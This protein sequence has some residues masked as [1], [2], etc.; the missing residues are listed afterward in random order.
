MVWYESCWTG[1]WDRRIGQYCD[2]YGDFTMHF[3]I[4]RFEKCVAYF[5]Q[6]YFGCWTKTKTAKS[7]KYPP[8]I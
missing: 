5:E 2:N 3:P 6:M 1:F 7:G 4:N 8:Y